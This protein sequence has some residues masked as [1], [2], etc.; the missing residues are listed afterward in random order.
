MEI[1]N[2]FGKLWFYAPF[3]LH[4]RIVNQLIRHGK[5]GNHIEKQKGGRFFKEV[6]G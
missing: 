2:G 5:Q 3:L 4:L 1:L 6:A